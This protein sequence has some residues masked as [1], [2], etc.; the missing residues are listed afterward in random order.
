MSG[1]VLDSSFHNMRLPGVFPL[2]PMDGKLQSIIGL[3]QTPRGATP[4]YGLYRYVPG[5]GVGF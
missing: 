5:D 4:I 2:L 3:T 1:I